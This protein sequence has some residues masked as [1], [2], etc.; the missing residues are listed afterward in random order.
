MFFDDD[1]ILLNFV[2]I[3]GQNSLLKSLFSQSVFVFLYTYIKAEEKKFS[4][5]TKCVYVVFFQK[6]A[7]DQI[8]FIN[9]RPFFQV[10]DLTGFDCHRSSKVD[11]AF[12]YLFK[13]FFFRENPRQISEKQQQPNQPAQ[14]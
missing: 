14:N 4:L 8:F 13:Q 12:V 2:L 11:Q 10:D 1:K 3:F 9:H 7:C 5:C 6:S